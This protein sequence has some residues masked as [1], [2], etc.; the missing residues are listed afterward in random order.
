MADDFGRIQPVSQHF[1]DRG[2]REEPFP[3]R[4]SKKHHGNDSGEGD[5]E[6]DESPPEAAQETAAGTHID[7]RI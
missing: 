1:L 4:N 5:T 6:M 3:G 2:A 7:F